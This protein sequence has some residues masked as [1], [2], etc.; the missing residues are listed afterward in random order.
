MKN[1]EGV[2]GMRRPI[3]APYFSN[4]AVLHKR[5]LANAKLGL[6]ATTGSYIRIELYVEYVPSYNWLQCQTI[7]SFSL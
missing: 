5:L 3:K 6:V 1:K 2:R 7:S 4:G